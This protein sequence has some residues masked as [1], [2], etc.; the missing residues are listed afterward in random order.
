MRWTLTAVCLWLTGAWDTLAETEIKSLHVKTD[1][2]HRY[3]STTV[4]SLMVNSGDQIEEAS[5]VVIYPDSAF[6]T[7]FIIEANGKVYKAKMK[8]KEDVKELVKENGTNIII[9]VRDSHQISVST[10][11]EAHAEVKFLMD[12]EELL[13]RKLGIYSNVITLNPGQIVKDLNVTVNIEEPSPIT[14]LE[15][16][17]FKDFNE[18]TADIFKPN[19]LV[20]IHEKSPY[21]KTI[22]WAPTAEQ[23]RAI[24]SRGLQGQ[25]A[26]RYSLDLTQG[27][28]L[29]QYVIDNLNFVANFF[30]IDD[31]PNLN[32]HIIFVLEY[33]YSTRSDKLEELRKAMDTIL[34]DL[35]RNDYFS[36][37]LIKSFV[38]AW[39]PDTIYITG[40]DAAESYDREHK[41]KSKHFTSTL[42]PKFLV[43]ASPENVAKARYYLISEEMD[44]SE[45][46]N[47]NG[48]LK[49]AM[50]LANLGAKKWK[51]NPPIPL[52][53]FFSNGDQNIREVDADF[54]QIKAL[55]IIQCPIYSLA[56]GYHSN[57]DF[58]RKLSISNYGS[59]HV[60]YDATDIV[61]QI[62]DFYR[63]V[64][65]PLLTDITIS[66]FQTKVKNV[67]RSKYPLYFRGSEIAVAGKVKRDATAGLEPIG[68]LSFTSARAAG[69]H[70]Y[71]LTDKNIFDGNSVTKLYEYLWISQMLEQ[72]E[73]Q[74]ELQEKQKI[75]E[76]L[77]NMAIECTFFTAY[78][79][80]VVE[81]P[82]GTITV[83]EITALKQEYLEKTELEKIKWIRPHLI[84]SAT[85]TQVNVMIKGEKYSLALNPT[86]ETF[87]TCNVNHMAG[88][89]RHFQSC[90]LEI[91]QDVSDFI[92]FKCDITANFLGVCCPLHLN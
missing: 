41:L 33:S 9:F 58:L 35:N 78:T 21:S 27:H 89:C 61:G 81:K 72:L 62:M 76:S 84:R 60:V 73:S 51:A 18:A 48:G 77:L 75:K 17:D 69:T 7:R 25:L 45:A 39:S 63:S 5:F 32:K 86:N 79:P 92:P 88:E 26:V 68:E 36:I 24:N 50:N 14:N 40:P 2:F 16:R 54:D 71:S 15:V 31:F 44:L 67:T 42:T 1:I 47:V 43:E 11:L 91:F 38:E 87:G 46:T 53:L 82:D 80:L 90:P 10:K 28:H 59:I 20:N 49:T 56:V 19:K 6:I 30:S 83:V 29:Q 37:I 74:L 3:A 34:R 55:N 22:V 64:A 70:N 57:Y 85:A 4:S 8:N 13:P 23:Q 65:S 52:I 66:Y 12:Y